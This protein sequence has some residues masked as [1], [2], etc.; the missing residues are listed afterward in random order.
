MLAMG[1]HVPVQLT[2]KITITV[3]Y[4]CWS[5]PNLAQ[6]FLKCVL[7]TVCLLGILRVM[8]YSGLLPA[9]PLCTL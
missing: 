8:R 7:G 2:H 5:Q 6:P 3:S 1:T 9:F 4:E